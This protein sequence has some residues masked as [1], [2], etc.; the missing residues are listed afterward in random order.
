MIFYF[1][2]TGNSLQA[3]KELGGRLG[4][5]VV[6]IAK[7]VQKKK[8]EYEIEAG[9]T[10]GFVFPV[11]FWGIPSI[12]AHFMFHLE[13]SGDPESY[14]FGVITC[15]GSIGAADQRLRRLTEKTGFRLKAVFPLVMPDNYLPMYDVQKAEEQ[16]AI[17][18]KAE[19]KLKEI[20]DQV[21][22][23]VSG[24]WSGPVEAAK[25]AALYPLYRKGRKTDKFYATD[26][27]VSCGRCASICPSGAI[28][29][30]YG[31]PVW[32]KERCV[33]CMG[34]I[35][36]CPAEAI[37]YGKKTESRGRYVNPVLD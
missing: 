18:E 34:C 23:H 17:L 24:T 19:R 11:Y 7:A 22:A 29:I 2:G 1:T 6:D 37:Q 36:R 4:E 33:F 35:N 12:V 3:A 31:K 15:G 10:V 5:E 26:A 9:E 8:F 25:T 13:L 32:V 14:C 16:E 30:E 21:A 27:C 28:E 20:A